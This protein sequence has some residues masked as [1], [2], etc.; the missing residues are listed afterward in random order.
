MSGHH[1][2]VIYTAVFPKCDHIHCYYLDF[3]DLNLGNQSPLIFIHLF[4]NV[5]T[6]SLCGLLITC[7]HLT[8]LLSNLVMHTQCCIFSTFYS[9]EPSQSAATNSLR[10]QCLNT[11]QSAFCAVTQI[12]SLHLSRSSTHR[13]NNAVGRRLVVSFCG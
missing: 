4:V 9:T 12:S 11:Q 3:S 13:H 1:I 5:Y 7:L 8:S 6:V 2:T 10:F